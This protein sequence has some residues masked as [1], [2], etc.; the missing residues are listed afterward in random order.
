MPRCLLAN[1]ERHGVAVVD[2]DS[3]PDSALINLLPDRRQGL[4]HSM[5]NADISIRINRS[6]ASLTAA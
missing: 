2:D 3:I 1:L 6:G 4:H 5:R